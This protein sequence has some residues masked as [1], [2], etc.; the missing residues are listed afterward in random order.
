VYYS[1]LFVQF[2]YYA[3]VITLNGIHALVDNFIPQFSFWIRH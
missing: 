1:L 2:T 3:A